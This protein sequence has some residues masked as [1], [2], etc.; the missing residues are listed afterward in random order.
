MKDQQE[1]DVA[2]LQEIEQELIDLIFQHGSGELQD[3][4]IEWQNQ[5]TKCNE[6]YFVYLQSLLNEYNEIGIKNDQHKR[7]LSNP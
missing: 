2:K 6:G 5:R 1:K 3:K 7:E 4:F